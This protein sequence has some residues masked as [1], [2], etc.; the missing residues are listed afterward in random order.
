MTL[1]DGDD[2]TLWFSVFTIRNSFSSFF[3]PS[4]DSLTVNVY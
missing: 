3:Y 2:K 1:D 4:G